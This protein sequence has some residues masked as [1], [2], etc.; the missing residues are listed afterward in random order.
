MERMPRE[1]ELDEIELD[2]VQQALEAI[3]NLLADAVQATIDEPSPDPARQCARQFFD[4]D[5]HAAPDEDGGPAQMMALLTL[6][7]WL[8]LAREELADRP[9]RPGRVEDVLGWIEEH[10]GKRYRARARYTSGLLESKD[11]AGEVAI[12]QHALQEEF[13]PALVWLL[14]GAVA[15]F[16]EGKIAW[17]R[18]LD[19]AG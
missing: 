3:G 4:I 11:A 13:L 6:V 14:A 5:A 2:E 15:R 1:I 19:G 17:L 9:D 16:G 12:Y 8:S 10:L 18:A 7:R